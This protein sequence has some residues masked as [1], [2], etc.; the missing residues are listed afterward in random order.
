I[1]AP[2]AGSQLLRVMSWRGLFVVLAAIGLANLAAVAGGLPE[3][4]PPGRRRRSGLGPT[5][6]TFLRLG[7]ERAFVGYVLAGGLAF[8][9]MFAYIAGSPFVLEDVYGISP[10]LFGVI[11][12]LN[13]LGLVACGQ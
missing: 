6:R 7:Q 4:L 9:A 12:A 13:A 11:F 2:I 1:V 8:G 3:T 10:Q 5:V